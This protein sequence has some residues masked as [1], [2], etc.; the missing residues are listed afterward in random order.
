MSTELT[1]NGTD[2]RVYGG[3]PNLVHIEDG[4]RC[5]AGAYLARELDRA[6][7][8]AAAK[9]GANATGA[10]C[11]GCYMIA[12][13]NAAIELANANG[14]PVAELGR[15][16]STAFVRLADRPVLGM[17]EEILVI[18]DIDLQERY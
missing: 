15:T 6:M 4:Q 10:L 2:G 14:Q 18:L 12:I 16:L 1:R 7:R 9:R 3:D 17:T 8:I 13:F 11:P 5:V